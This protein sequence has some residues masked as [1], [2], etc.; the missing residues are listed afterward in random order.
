MLTLRQI[1]VIRAVMLT[2]TVAGA[3]RLLNVAAPGLSR[4][5]KH[6]E[7]SLGA[8]LFSR[9][10]GRF[11]PAPEARSIFAQINELHRNLDNLQFAIGALER[12]E[13]AEFKFG[14][15]P[16][17]AQVMAPLAVADLRRRYPDLLIDF[18][19]LKLEDAI[20][21]L[22]LGRGEVAAVSSRL[23]HPAI[24]FEPLAQGELFCIVAEEH[25]LA[26]RSR[27][28]AAEIAA[29][30][31]IGIDPRDPYGRILTEIFAR[32]RLEYQAPIKARFGATVCALVRQNLGIGVI[33]GF[34]LAE[35]NSFG[36]R[37]IPIEEDTTF[38][39]YVAFRN[40]T[41]LSSV[42]EFFIA[43][44][45][46]RMKKPHDAMAGQRSRPPARREARSSLRS[47]A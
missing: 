8:K 24:T 35:Q 6:T 11:V 41:T 43:A 32:A 18:D 47:R 21:F 2:G 17:I 28:A 23:E 12:G 30:P 5:M 10:G 36:L 19:I 9:R 42:A 34:T 46:A 20:D 37:V 44:L 29:H 39:T 31:L 25:P 26:S 22:L 4:L 40:D 38:S 16:S 1:E 33:D 15:T 14:A 13:G 27:I 45:R 3:A 7:D